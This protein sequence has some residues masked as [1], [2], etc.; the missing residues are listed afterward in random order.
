V[1][2][3]QWAC[4]H[5]SGGRDAHP[6]RI[7]PEH[8][9]SARDRVPDEP[10][11]GGRLYPCE[12]FQP[13]ASTLPF[14]CYMGSVKPLLAV[15]PCRRSGAIPRCA[16]F[17]PS[18]RR[19]RCSH[20]APSLLQNA[21]RTAAPRRRASGWISASPRFWNT[22]LWRWPGRSHAS[23]TAPGR[24]W[25]RLSPSSW[26]GQLK[27]RAVQLD[28]DY[29]ARLPIR[30]EKHPASSP[31]ITLRALHTLKLASGSRRRCN[32]RSAHVAWPA[33]APRPPSYRART[34]RGASPPQADS[35][36]PRSLRRRA[37][38]APP[39]SSPPGRRSRPR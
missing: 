1:L 5:R 14:N 36:A 11:A 23:A 31:W 25:S 7:H 13:N 26:T 39:W 16:L 10:P 35:P 32:R 38:R 15:L 33:S 9:D 29:S 34:D 12:R 37:P 4:A 22:D 24:R 2:D 3:G 20:Y 18:A 21:P 30:I 19:G 27:S 17:G 28:F 8:T 6:L